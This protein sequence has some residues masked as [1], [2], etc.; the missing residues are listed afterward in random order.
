MNGRS[1]GRRRPARRG[2]EG[3]MTSEAKAT[4][5]IAERARVADVPAIH[6]L[7]QYWADETGDV[8]ARTEGEIYE[9]LRDFLVVRRGD[10]VIV[11]GAL[12]IEWKDLAEV[13]SLVVDPG[14]QGGGLGRIVVEACLEEAVALGIPTVFAL[15]TSPAFFERIGFSQAAVS[16][17]PRKVWHECFRCPKY[18]RCDE[19][20]VSI[21]LRD[22]LR[23]APADGRP[24]A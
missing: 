10:R 21:D 7:I 24:L 1:R 17:F 9:S 2:C 14:E 16:A 18:A 15:T 5:Q 11:A 12:H 6:R 4:P 22:R 23:P 13:K 19:I 8:L 20:A 3:K